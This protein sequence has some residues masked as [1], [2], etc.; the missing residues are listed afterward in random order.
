MYPLDS[1]FTCRFTVDD[2]NQI[3]KIQEFI[4]DDEQEVTSPRSTSNNAELS[5]LWVD[6]CWQPIA[7]FPGLSCSGGCSRKH[8]DSGLG[9]TSCCVGNSSFPFPIVE[10]SQDIMDRFG[11]W[12]WWGWIHTGSFLYGND[13][14]VVH[15]KWHV[16]WS[17]Q[18]IPIV[19][20]SIVR[21]CESTHLSPW[22]RNSPCNGYYSLG[23]DVCCVWPFWIDWSVWYSGKW[24]HLQSVDCP[25]TLYD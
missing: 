11:A 18:N 13:R 7:T 9:R 12:R 23:N 6:C 19:G 22:I 25:C 5:L 17:G 15:W 24:R 1:I 14:N 10:F 21:S 2:Q 4:D 16:G 3:R 20:Y 8:Q